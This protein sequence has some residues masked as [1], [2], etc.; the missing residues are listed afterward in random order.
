MLAQLLPA[1]EVKTIIGVIFMAFSRA[2]R[3]HGN[4]MVMMILEGVSM[5]LISIIIKCELMCNLFT[6]LSSVC[7]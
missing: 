7:E 1:M 5:L 6:A 4:E 2:T 3:S